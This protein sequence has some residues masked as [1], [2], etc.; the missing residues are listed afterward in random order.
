MSCTFRCRFPASI[1]LPATRDELL[2]TVI[3]QAHFAPPPEGN[4][5]DFHPK[6]SGYADS[7]RSSRGGSTPSVADVLSAGEP[8]ELDLLGALRALAER[9]RRAA[10]PRRRDHRHVARRLP[11]A[12]FLRVPGHCDSR[13]PTGVA[14]LVRPPAALAGC[15][16]LVRGRPARRS[17]GDAPDRTGVLRGRG[18]PAVGH[19]ARAV[20][21]HADLA[22][23]HD[24]SGRG[25]RL[26]GLRPAAA[27]GPLPS[28]GCIDDP[29]PDLGR[30]AP[31]AVLRTLG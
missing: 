18:S 17:G 9:A 11:G 16:A 1:L 15:A 2:P 19:G 14:T 20:R 3:E 29:G 25:A 31:A 23:R 27:A 24:R 7:H 6:R 10:D 26:E 4:N 28:P 30:V 12:D 21:P 5:H 22:V 8:A 13:R